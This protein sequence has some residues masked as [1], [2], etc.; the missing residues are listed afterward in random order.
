MGFRL[1][2]ILA[3]CEGPFI[4]AATETGKYDVLCIRGNVFQQSLVNKA[5]QSAAKVDRAA[6]KPRAWDG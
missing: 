4:Q 2:G 1:E 3:S 6:L 5:R